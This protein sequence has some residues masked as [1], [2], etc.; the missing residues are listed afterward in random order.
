[1]KIY[2]NQPGTM[3]N[4]ENPPGTMNNHENQL[5]TMKNR[6]LSAWGHA[7]VKGQRKPK[8]NQ[9]CKKDVICFTQISFED[10]SYVCTQDL[11]YFCSI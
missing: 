9:V 5:G 7:V 2:E 11:P 6:P 8:V 1:M 4:R 10:P 3:K